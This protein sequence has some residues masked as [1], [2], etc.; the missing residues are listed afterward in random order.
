[1]EGGKAVP[2]RGDEPAELLPTEEGAEAQREQ[3]GGGG[4]LGQTGEAAT[5]AGGGKKVTLDAS[6]TDERGRGSDG[7]RP[8]L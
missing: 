1:M 7:T 3:R 2:Q 6:R 8:F 5:T 4:Q